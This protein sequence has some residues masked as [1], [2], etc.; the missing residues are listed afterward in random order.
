MKMTDSRGYR[1]QILRG[2][3]IAAVVFLH[4]TP[5]GMP[6]VYI[7]PFVNF[8][9]GMFIFLSGMLSDGENWHPLKRV[10]KVIVPYI[11]WSVIFTL[12]SF[13][14]EPA[15]LPA[16]IRWNLMTG[17]AAG[18]LYYIFVYCEF[19]L[20]IPLIDLLAKSKLKYLGFLVAP[21]EIIYFRLM[22]L[23]NG[24]RFDYNVRVALGLS[25]LGWFTYFY[26]GYLLGN[27]LI[28]IRMPNAVLGFLILSSLAV[29]VAEGKWYYSM[30]EANAGTQLK[31]SAILSG[32]LICVAAYRFICAEAPD[33]KKWKT[34]KFFHLLG[35][36]SFSVYFAHIFFLHLFRD[37]GIFGEHISF[38]LDALIL[39]IVSMAFAVAGKKIFG[40][41]GRFMAF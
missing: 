16:L 26:L 39:I 18:I 37:A 17:R 9:V 10:L 33:I 36:C 29:Q 1:I 6:E 23:M 30:S 40:K 22:P 5:S 35:D 2:I 20:L 21:A 11:I 12:Q 8:G 19:T 34:L 15:E 4:C 28:K 13:E 25:C 27:G 14:G 32:A 7:R 38:P 24:T 41:F 31:L 3:A